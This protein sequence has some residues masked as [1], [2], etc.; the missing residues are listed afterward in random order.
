MAQPEQSKTRFWLPLTPRGVAAFARGSW[1]R[2]LW[3]Q[4]IFAALVGAAMTWFL[5]AAW[6]PTIHNAIR[7][8]PER[9][10]ISSGVLTAFTNAPQLLAEGQFLALALDP[11]H[12]GQ[13]RSLAHVQVE[14]GRRDVRVSSLFGYAT[15]DYPTRSNIAFNRT[16][17][18][19]WWGAWRPPILWLTFGGVIVWLVIMWPVLGA[20]YLLPVWLVGFFANRDL[21]W[22]GSWKLASASLL[23]GALVV[24]VALVLYGLGLLDL[25]QFVA[26][27]I[28]HLVMGW[29]YAGI[30]PLFLPRHPAAERRGKNPFAR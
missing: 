24:A 4:F 3:V 6:F 5:D 20:V 26:V 17:L 15:V 30:S 16:D 8:L 19:P 27:Q 13:I 14:F 22:R 28:G 11:N 18:E 2:L 21:D 9:G 29:I 7:K 25:V 10:E 23:P 12:S 1:W